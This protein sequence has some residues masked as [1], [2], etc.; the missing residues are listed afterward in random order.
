MTFENLKNF[1]DESLANLPFKANEIVRFRKSVWEQDFR[2]KKKFLRL[3]NDFLT[4][5]RKQQIVAIVVHISLNDNNLTLIY[6]IGHS[7]AVQN[8]VFIYSKGL[9]IGD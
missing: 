3:K 1:Q 9:I 8:Y 2:E 4:I 5:G 7:F 6:N